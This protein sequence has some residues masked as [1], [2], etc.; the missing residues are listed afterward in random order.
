MDNIMKNRG[1]I[2]FDE[3]FNEELSLHIKSHNRFIEEIKVYINCK[4]NQ[5]ARLERE[6][7]EL[8]TKIKDMQGIR[9]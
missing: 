3:L 4:N 5:I 9:S 2:S 1:A 7:S 6:N 8:K